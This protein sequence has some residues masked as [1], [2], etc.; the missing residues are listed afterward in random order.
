[1]SATPSESPEL[2]EERAWLRAGK[3]R[4]AGLLLTVLVVLVQVLFN[5]PPEPVLR[6]ATFDTYQRLLPRHRVND[7]VVIVE[8]DD[9]SLAKIGQWPWPRSVI[10]ELLE[11]IAADKPAAIAIDIVF[12]E[13]D[14]QSPRQQRAALVAQNVIPAS[15]P[16]AVLPD[17]DQRLSDVLARVR[18][19]LGVSGLDADPGLPPTIDYRPPI[20]E[21]GGQAI[22]S[23]PNY[24]AAVRSLD[25]LDRAAGGHGIING[26]AERDGILRRMPALGAV[27][28]HLLP[29]FAIEALRLASGDPVLRVRV[30]R[31]GVSGVTVGELPIPTDPDAGVWIH[32]SD[33]GERPRFPALSVLQGTLQPGLMQGRIVLIGTSAT[34]LEDEIATPAGL[35]SGVEAH[36]ETIENVLDQRVLHRPVWAP[37]A[38]AAL[39]ALL[40]LIGIF[41]IPTRRPSYAI[42]GLLVGIAF[43]AGLGYFAFSDFAVL[44][45][46]LTPS[47][48]A[49]LVFGFMLILTLNAAEMQRN[50][51][52]LALLRTREEQ[53]RI[54]GELDA[55]RRIQTG[56]LPTPASVV[57]D[58]TRID[59]AALMQPARTVGGDLFDFFRIDRNRLFFMVGDVSGKGLPASLFMALS[60]AL[61]KDAMLQSG[62]GDPAQGLTQANRAIAQE[63]PESLFVSVAAGVIDLETGQL[64]WCCA[65]HENPWLVRSGD[66][67]VIRLRGV[68][69]PA[70]CMVDGF[71]YTF[72]RLQM[73]PGD[74]LCLVTDGITEASNPGGQF[75]G[76]DRLLTGLATAAEELTS[77]RVVDRIRTDVEAFAAGTEQADDMTVLVLRWRGPTR[78][79]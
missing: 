54:E 51:L 35:M 59:L 27:G 19:V 33:P 29:G 18:P 25:L 26:S 55:A 67:P 20:L 13:A 58:D 39:T 68:G 53:A 23:V 49:S 65:G 57:G 1:M 79:S 77:R 45:D 36:A 16:P 11:R 47:F 61:I 70:L 10:A 72:E 43:A 44:L 52:R 41:V 22:E 9:S 66:L 6:N 12:A 42:L 7:S 76:N 71:A 3:G 24:P 31:G 64:N 62:G 8:I 40:A 4:P 21:Q 50:T 28:G 34:A 17:F 5:L 30:G 48:G 14:R 63:N 74:A 37:F 73:T 69:G 46:V 32:F 15:T 78:A 2:R 75:F 60:K 38:E 56:M